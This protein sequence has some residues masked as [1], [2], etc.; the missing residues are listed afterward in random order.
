MIRRY[1][2]IFMND[3]MYNQDVLRSYGDATFDRLKAA[4]AEYDPTGFFSTR[5]KGWG[6]DL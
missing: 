4:A 6:F 2:P 3:A 1:N 5:Q